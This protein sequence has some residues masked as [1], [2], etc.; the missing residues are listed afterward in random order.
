MATTKF[1]GR[2]P[3]GSQPNNGKVRS[4]NI[5]QEQNCW[6]K[7][8]EFCH[9]IWL[10]IYQFFCCEKNEGSSSVATVETVKATKTDSMLGKTSLPVKQ[11][12]GSLEA[13]KKTMDHV[14]REDFSS[15]NQVAEM[16]NGCTDET[17]ELLQNKQKISNERP[18]EKT[19]GHPSGNKVGS[20]QPVCNDLSKEDVTR[21]NNKT[22]KYEESKPPNEACSS[23]EHLPEEQ[24]KE[25]LEREI[26]NEGQTPIIGGAEQAG[27]I[28][29]KQKDVLNQ[30]GVNEDTRHAGS[31][32]SETAKSSV[33]EEVACETS[34]NKEDKHTDPRRPERFK[35]TVVKELSIRASFDEDDED[36]D[37]SAP[38]VACSS[39]EHLPEEQRKEGLEREIKNES[40]TP[41]ICGAKQAGQII[42]KQKDVLNQA[43]VNEDTRHAGSSS[44]ET[45]KSSI[46][47]KVACETSLNKEDKHTDPRRPERFK[48]TVV[49]E[50]SIR[51]SFDED[52]EDTDTS[53][54]KMSKNS[55]EEN[56]VKQA[57]S[58]K[59][60]KCTD[61]TPPKS[62]KSSA[63]EKV[64]KPRSFKEDD[65]FTETSPAKTGKSSTEQKVAEK[66]SLKKEDKFTETIHPKT[67][68]S[69]IGQTLERQGN[70]SKD[71]KNDWQTVV[72]PA[73]FSKDD[74]KSDASPPTTIKSSDGEKLVGQ[75]S[76]KKEDEYRKTNHPSKTSKSEHEQKGFGK[77]ESNNEKQVNTR[78]SSSMVTDFSSPGQGRQLLSKEQ[79]KGVV[80]QEGIN[81]DDEN[82]G[83]SYTDTTKSSI[84]QA[85]KERQKEIH[86][87]D[88]SYESH[89]RNTKP[90]HSENATSGSKQEVN[91]PLSNQQKGFQQQEDFD[92]KEKFGFSDSFV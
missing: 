79:E 7:F 8:C 73:S 50:L 6:Q 17:G 63:G 26:K 76:F 83:I 28:I 12:N 39:F 84:R 13:G 80:K 56:V 9:S 41:I 18:A 74:R 3:K 77:Q 24:R 81:K 68:K 55:A 69:S 31:S 40:Q 10:Q 54:S 92:E 1:R 33:G 65:K 19:G 51:A 64:F 35:S 61:T 86:K 47:D 85:S 90:D 91:M 67:T 32:S 30:A 60:D 87:Q 14:P 66:E 4:K 5:P 29:E 25:G 82:T 52:D 89:G 46:G 21:K 62:S 48:S 34:L 43:G 75:E 38:N 44:S 15:S 11:E 36:T 20:H 78:L 42:E 22:G 88:K 49:K 57:R 45:T 53:S 16:E 37:T 59:E 72:K 2:E 70:F 23:F 71:D 27:Q 58:V